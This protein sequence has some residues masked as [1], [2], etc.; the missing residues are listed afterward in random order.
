M[1]FIDHLDKLAQSKSSNSNDDFAPGIPEKGKKS[2]IPTGGDEKWTINV[3]R[4]QAKKAG[5][6][7]DL[8]LNPQGSQT[9][10]S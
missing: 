5:D 3:Q 10:Y 7:H 8:R 1:K 2:P 6:H 4:H 9:A